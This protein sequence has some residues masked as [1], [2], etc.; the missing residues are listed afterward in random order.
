MNISKLAATM[1]AC[2]MTALALPGC[3]I[4]TTPEPAPVRPSPTYGSLTVTWSVAGSFAA[5][6]CDFYNASNL[7]LTVYDSSGRFYTRETAPCAQFDI[8]VNLPPGV[9][10][11]DVTLVDSRNRAVSTTKPLEDIVITRGTDLA[12]DLDFP[13]NSML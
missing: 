13:A 10:T 4:D 1:A 5:S 12:I 9:Y 6:R 8:S 3:I 2:A 11:A 7:E